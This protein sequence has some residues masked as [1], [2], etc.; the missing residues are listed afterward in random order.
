MSDH[1]VQLARHPTALLVR[2]APRAQRLFALQSLGSHLHLV[3]GRGSD[4]ERAADGKR[5]SAAQDPEQRVANRSA[6]L[7]VPGDK[8]GS[9]P[10]HE[11]E[12]RDHGWPCS[13]A[14]AEQI[15]TRRDRGRFERAVAR[16]PARTHEHD[17]PR[18]RDD[19][20]EHSTP[21]P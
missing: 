3:P 19:G 15:E 1:V 5:Q 4:R 2:G 16:I 18:R 12:D 11:R 13:N 14:T 8:R 7:A 21:T 9:Q 10:E 6:R 17:Q 20:R